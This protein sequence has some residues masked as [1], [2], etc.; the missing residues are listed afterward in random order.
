M[1]GS[2]FFMSDVHLGMK[3]YKHK[4]L[5]ED[6]VISFFGKLIEEKAAELVIAGDFFDS[7]IEYRHVVPKGFYRIFSKMYDLVNAGVKVTYLAGNHDFWRGRYLQEEFGIEKLDN[8]VERVINGKKFYIHHGDG[9]AYNDLGYRILKVILRN[10]AAQFFYGL[11]HPDFAL[12]LAKSTSSKSRDYTSQKDYSVKDGLKDE[13]LRK[14]KEGN[15][16]VLMGHRHKP[17]MIKENGGYYV[18]LGDWMKSFTY[19]EFD[20]NK[21]YFRKYFDF[22]SQKIVE[23]LTGESD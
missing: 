18:N 22:N 19:G 11:L 13:A 5:Q 17:Q 9:L 21:F 7:W 16:F 4:K 12:W 2:V 15:D 3:H 10:K 14:I 6:L 1:P 20:G 8:H 23:E